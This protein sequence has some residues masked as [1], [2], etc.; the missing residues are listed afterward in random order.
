MVAITMND[1]LFVLI[2]DPS[3]PVSDPDTPGSPDVPLAAGE[4]DQYQQQWEPEKPISIPAEPAQDR[5]HRR[6]SFVVIRPPESLD[7]LLNQ[8]QAK[9][10]PVRQSSSA[11]SKGSGIS[12]G[13]QVSIEGLVF[14]VG[15][16]WI[17]RA[18]NIILAG[19]TT[20]GMLLEAE[21]LPLPIPPQPVV[22]V[23]DTAV[24]LSNMLT[25]L[26]PT[27]F[28]AKTLV[29]PITDAHWE[30]VLFDTDDREDRPLTRPNNDT[31]EEGGQDI[32][33]TSEDAIPK[34]RKGDWTGDHRDQRSA[35]LI[36]G[37][38]KTEGIV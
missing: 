31:D 2:E 3:V 27:T 13:A 24:L 30:D 23:D 33:I 15:T 25:S 10:V 29:F 28:G 20:R 26:L 4:Q 21:Y 7:L 37:A 14:S 5:T 36:T 16:D 34:P 32:Y 22:T 35:F 38:L 9:W 11:A 17:I 8:L 12:G 19:G 1:A 18:G 6:T